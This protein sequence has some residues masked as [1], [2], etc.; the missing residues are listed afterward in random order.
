VAEFTVCHLPGAMPNPDRNETLG[1]VA[2]V[3]ADWIAGN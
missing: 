3:G 2:K 1:S